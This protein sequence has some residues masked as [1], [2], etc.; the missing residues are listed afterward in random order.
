M[1]RRR[2]VAE[3]TARASAE[4]MLVGCRPRAVNFLQVFFFR[5]VININS[6]CDITVSFLKSLLLLIQYISVGNFFLF[7]ANSASNFGRFRAVLS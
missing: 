2:C 3:W 7:G 5:V 4:P 6:L 1:L